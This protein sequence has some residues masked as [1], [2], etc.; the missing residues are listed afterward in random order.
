MAEAQV[1]IQL[2][3][4]DK[5]SQ[6][7]KSHAQALSHAQEGYE[8]LSDYMKRT[9]RE[10]ESVSSAQKQA[11]DAAKDAGDSAEGAS[12]SW[13]GL[14]KTFTLASL[15][16]SA[17]QKGLLMATDTV[18]DSIKAAADYERSLMGLNAAGA[19]F[20]HTTDQINTAIKAVTND[21]LLGFSTAAN[22]LKT[23]LSTG[24]DMDTATMLMQRFKDE[25]AFGRKET[26]DYGQ[27]VENLAQAYKTQSS[28]LGDASGHTD[29]F[30]NALEIGANALGKTVA[31]LSEAE[32]EQAK[33]IGYMQ[34]GAHTAGN[35][36][37]FADTYS[38]SLARMEAESQKAS[39]TLG[40][41]LIPA[42]E[43][44]NQSFAS[45]ISALT[46]TA[47]AS[48]DVQAYLVTLAAI[49][50]SVAQVVVGAAQIVWGALNSIATMSWQPFLNGVNGAAAGF[51]S[52]WEDAFTQYEKI[53][54]DSMSGAAGAQQ[55]ALN[56]M[57]RNNGAAQSRMA[58]QIEDANRQFQRQMEQRRRSFE[59]SL[60]DM[61]ISHRD[62]SRSIQDDISREQAAY[63]AANLKRKQAY[64]EDLA[65]LEE[66]HL[67]KVQSIEAQISDERQ[68]GLE[69][70]GVLYQTANEKK[71]AKLEEQLRKEAESHQK[72]LEKRKA[73][74][75]EDVASDQQRHQERMEQL[76]RSLN[77]ELQVLN[78][79]R[80]DVAAI[81]NAVKEDDITRLKRQYAEANAEAVRNHNEQLAR[82]RQQG[83]AQGGV[84][85]GA[86]TG[87]ANG[88]LNSML[89]EHRKRMEQMRQQ[90][91][92]GGDESAK[93]LW[94]NFKAGF[95]R[96][97]RD[98]PALIDRHTGALSGLAAIVGAVP[99]G[100]GAA[101]WLRGLTG[102]ATGGIVRTG[103]TTLTGERGPE[104][105]QFPPG[106]RI[107][108]SDRSSQMLNNAG[109]QVLVSIGTVIN[110]SNMD[111][112]AFLS[113]LS[114]HLR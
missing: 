51:E 58:Q 112:D 16:A 48:Q 46:G 82:L 17:I 8:S 62:K 99:G 94:E 102:R 19:A 72:A 104:I 15:A 54:S 86:F 79:H 88:S 87:A 38:G 101:N 12:S 43:Y 45:F 92:R 113:G 66:R 61:I 98:L 5:A 28:T 64:D 85:G 67:D 31:Q 55:S 36:A 71:I 78:R 84:Y 44:V 33:L 50:R 80:S 10:A 25:A 97:F 107:I 23:L 91:A 69:V 108:P 2:T 59:E 96:W 21:G 9:S 73:K 57:V 111:A 30:S 18:K 1:K 14:F 63:D 109:K 35:A 11:S 37:Q 68:K 110:Q 65:A 77:E 114:W 106:T 7:F 34:Q 100:G 6:V 40:Q 24:M 76:Q 90:S 49:V 53:Y 83:G 52:T 75:N 81:G 47:T 93:S 3:A 13:S 39:I 22:A 89:E 105:A 74:Y 70:D 27:A 42:A 41:M 60:R 20:G 29:N 103:E 4:E 26:I 95:I 56:D 32:K